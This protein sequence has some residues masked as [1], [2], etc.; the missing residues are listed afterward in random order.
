MCADLVDVGG[1]LVLGLRRRVEGGRAAVAGPRHGVGDP[2]DVLLDGDHHVR[3]HG[4]AAGTG[5]HPEVRV[6][7][8]R[9][10]EVR[11]GS[12]GPLLLEQHA[13]APLDVERGQRPGHGVEAGGEHDRVELVLLLARAH[14]CLRHLRQRRLPEVDE[15]DVGQVERRVVVRVEARP[16]G[17]ERVIGRAQRLGDLGIGDD[18]ADPR[19]HVLRRRVVGLLVRDEVVVGEQ[20]P[21]EAPGLEAV[22][23]RGLSLLLAHL[24]RRLLG[25]RV[26]HAEAALA[27]LLAVLRVAGLQLG[28]HLRVERGVLRRQA[29]VRRALEHG[30][31][32]RLLGD[33][34]DR[35]DRR[36]AGADDPDALPGEVDALVRPVTRVVPVALEVLDARDLRHL[37]RRQAADGHDRRAGPRR[38]RPGRCARASAAPAR[39]TRPTR[40][41]ST[42]L[43]SRRRSKRSATWLA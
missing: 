42:N 37:R 15:R 25:R 39:R 33:H 21:D 1:P 29:E 5:D 35:L 16:L 26:G 13:V 41:G 31:L 24:E 14:A 32:G 8:R 38:A 23:V 28:H 27:R 17:A 40:P 18:L 30:E 11:A 3:E 7:G 20:H 22:V 34:R 6:A 43:M 2:V 10:P 19:P 36:R 9:D 12:F 4:R